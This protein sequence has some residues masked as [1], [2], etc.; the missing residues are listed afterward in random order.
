MPSGEEW[1]R[2][3]PDARHHQVENTAE[4]VEVGNRGTGFAFELLGGEVGE[5]T[6]QLPGRGQ[7]GRVLAVFDRGG[8][9]EIRHHHS[10]ARDV[11][12]SST[13]EGLKSRCTTP[14]WWAAARP[15][16]I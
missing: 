5:G 2:G 12:T 1:G 16:R 10:R 4:S 15:E 9:P 3:R 8:K 6:H 13:F 14:A 11:S 7:A